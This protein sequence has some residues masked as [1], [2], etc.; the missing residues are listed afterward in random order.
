MALGLALAYNSLNNTTG[1]YLTNNKITLS[2]NDNSVKLATNNTG[3]ALAVAGGV[4]V[5]AIEV[6]VADNKTEG[7]NTEKTRITTVGAGIGVGW[8]K[9]IFNLQGAAA[10]SDIYK[11]NR[12]SLNNTNINKSQTGNHP[13]INVTADTKNKINTVGAVGS[14]SVGDKVALAAGVAINRMN[15]DTKAE[16]AT[17][18]G[19]TTTVNAGLTQVRAIGDGDIHSVGVGSTIAIKA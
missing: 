19:K 2:G 4:E 15:Q 9:N 14:V 16:M 5:A 13:T 1:T 17:D 6:A 11:E 3:K 8:G 10:I 7:E 18:N 12:A